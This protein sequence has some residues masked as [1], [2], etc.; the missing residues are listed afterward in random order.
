MSKKDN[1][2]LEELEELRS[3]FSEY[4]QVVDSV[5]RLPKSIGGSMLIKTKFHPELTF[6][7]LEFM[8]NEKYIDIFKEAGYTF[9]DDKTRWDYY[10]KSPNGYIHIYDWKG[11]SV[12]IGSVSAELGTEDPRA[13]EDANLLND[14]IERSIGKFFEFRKANSKQYLNEYTFDNFMDAFVTLH[15]LFRRSR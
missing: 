5:A 12:S 15:L 8:F 6:H 3:E 10:L 1:Q 13:V 14:L 7:F 2:L 9:I 11:Y 4:F